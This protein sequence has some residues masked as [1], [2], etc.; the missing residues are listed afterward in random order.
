MTQ[1][2]LILLSFQLLRLCIGLVIAE[3]MI[4]EHRSNNTD[5]K[6]GVLGEKFVLVPLCL[7][8]RPA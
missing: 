6:I 4:V 5:G 8:H 7:S 2:E 3:R 1:A